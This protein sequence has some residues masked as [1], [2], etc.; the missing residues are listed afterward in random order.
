MGT[1]GNAASLCYVDGQWQEGNPPILGPRNHAV[2]LSSV[3]FDGARSIHR[4]APDLDLH[5]ARAVRSA[6]LLGLAPDRSAEEIIALAKAGVEQFPADA[7]LYVC[8]M[9]YAADG[10]IVPD[11]TSTQFVMSVYES[12][13]PPADGFSACISSY[14]RPATDMAPT[15]AKASC[16]Y[17]NVA[18]CVREATAKGFDTAVVPDPDGNVAEFAY[19]NLFIGLDGAVHTPAPNGTFLNG[20]TRQRVIQLLRDSGAE[21]FERTLT[22]DDV[23][24]ADEIFATGNYAKVYPCTRLEERT[25]SPGE[26]YKKARALYFDYARAHTL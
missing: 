16:L 26:M 12:P 20:I 17:P 3:V 24:G 2:W 6:E 4:M 5:C 21:V 15:E 11:P 14:R 7:E 13:L 25:L 23:R 18:R 1:T 19:M 8:P 9:F 10:F 22:I